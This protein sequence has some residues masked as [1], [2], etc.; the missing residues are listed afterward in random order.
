[1]MIRLRDTSPRRGRSALPSDFPAA[2]VRGLPAS[3]AARARLYLY[4]DRW[5][6]EKR[7]GKSF[8]LKLSRF[9]NLIRRVRCDQI[10]MIY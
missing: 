8:V 1:M 5:A 9:P 6:S 3:C 10:S 4:C 7:G 2:A